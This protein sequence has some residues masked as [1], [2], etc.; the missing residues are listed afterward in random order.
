MD[1]E[2]RDS[3]GNGERFV[4][5][6]AALADAT[7]AFANAATF[8][9]DTEFVR[10]RTYYPELCLIQIAS[11]EAIACIDCRAELDDA[12][13]FATLTRPQTAWVLHSARQDLEV[14][15]QR[16]GKLPSRLI[17]TQIA[18]ALLGHS[19][20]LGLQDLLS[21]EL[22]VSLGKEYTRTD[23]TRR[24]LPPAALRYAY[25]DVRFLLPAWAVLRQR[26]VELGRLDWFE[27]DCARLL[28]QPLASEPGA[29]LARTKGLAR[30][31]FAEQCAA[32][33]LVE[34]REQRARDSNR[35][36][37]WILP[38]EALV[39]ISRRA[40]SDP[41][42]LGAVDGLGRAFVPRWGATVIAA[43][44]AKDSAAVR[45]AVAALGLDREPDR[46]RLKLLKAKVK[47][48]AAALGIQPEVLASRRDLVA[49]TTDAPAPL[50]TSGWRAAVL[51][52]GDETRDA[53]G[54]PQ[55]SSSA[56]LRRS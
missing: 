33:T 11:E 46:A 47:A 44:Q 32:F 20:Q 55:L 9:L 41:A 28:A 50:L 36:R 18:A 6:A 12:G 5:D 52:T 49:L 16:Y 39:E 25:D 24:P 38:D 26:L 1:P 3:R 15:S 29:I 19:P 53:G 54:S 22:G 45:S 37:R 35:P 7:A 42:A 17:D 13:L 43:L 30:L 2:T 31:S 34:W 51:G 48:E 4:A 56:A 40:P 8:A 23:W 21:R 14:V 10:E 27:E